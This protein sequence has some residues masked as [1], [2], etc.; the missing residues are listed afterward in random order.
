L[1][2]IIQQDDLPQ[3]EGGVP[4]N[5]YVPERNETV[6]TKTLRQLYTEA[7][8]AQKSILDTATYENRADLTLEESRAF[9]KLDE[10]IATLKEN[11]D[12]DA[13]VDK[14]QQ[15]RHPTSA[16]IPARGTA[17]ISVGREPR[18]YSPDTDPHGVNFLKDVTRNFLYGDPNA[19]ERLVR[20]GRE[21][22]TLRPGLTERAAGD[23]TTA[24]WAGLVVPQYLVDMVAPAISPLRPFADLCCVHHDLPPEGMSVNFSKV[25]TGSQVIVQSAELGAIGAASMDDTL[26]TANVQTAAGYLNLSRQSID[27]G[28]GIEQQSF[29]DLSRKYAAAVDSQVLNQATT[30]VLAVAQN[31]AWVQASPTGAL[32]WP[33]LEQADSLLETAL[34]GVAFPTHVVMHS[35]RWHWLA[36]QVGTSFPFVG[37]A[38]VNAMQGGMLLTS[39]YGP[40]VRAK[41]S[42]GLLVVVDNNLPT[43]LG[44]GTEDPILV[45][46][47]GE[48]VHLWEDPQAPVFIRAEQ[49]NAPTLGVLLVLYGYFAFATRYA[50]PVSKITGTGLVAPA[51]F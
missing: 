3:S 25:T 15:E 20:H 13:E 40:S 1:A 10:I 21:E 30:G 18:T 37:T 49:P 9:N 41:L 46:A 47:A 50:N 17:S 12:K 44:G 26:G 34:L 14:R 38:G 4:F 2:G 29:L 5:F 8:D 35:R 27:R 31:T 23:V 19:A 28:T 48:S 16:A 7:M 42:S 6:M 39:E 11:M 32:L 43:N 51:G 33:F 24:N 45:A 36:S 22:L